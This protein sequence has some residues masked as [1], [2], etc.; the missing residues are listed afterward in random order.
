MKQRVVVR[1]YKT[2][3][4]KKQLAYFGIHVVVEGR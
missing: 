2:F 3:T 4:V 1:E